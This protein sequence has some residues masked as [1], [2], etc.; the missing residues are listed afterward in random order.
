VCL[1]LLVSLCREISQIALLQEWMPARVVISH[2][3]LARHGNGFV[4]RLGSD[5]LGQLGEY[6]EMKEKRRLMVAQQLSL[7]IQQ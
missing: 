1:S 4:V 2:H 6:D 7:I 5:L 3:W